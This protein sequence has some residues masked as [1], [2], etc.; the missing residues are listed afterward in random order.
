M[1][2]TDESL[3]NVDS[4]PPLRQ[5]AASH[6]LLRPLQATDYHKGCVSREISVD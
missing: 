5:P 6:F 1:A 4:L 2:T 3:F